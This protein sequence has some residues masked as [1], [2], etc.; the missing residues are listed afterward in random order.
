MPAHGQVMACPAAL[1]HVPVCV[2]PSFETVVCRCHELPLALAQDAC[3]YWMHRADDG[4]IFIVFDRLFCTCVGQRADEPCR[5]GLVRPFA[6]NNPRRIATHG[7]IMLWHA[8]RRA[9]GGRG[10]AGFGPPA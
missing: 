10:Q 7:W 1:V 2:M 3:D 9:H 6:S 8:L 4:G 5:Y